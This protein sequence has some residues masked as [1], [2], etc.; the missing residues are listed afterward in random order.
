MGHGQR[1]RQRAGDKTQEAAISLCFYA[2]FIRKPL[3]T[4]R[5]ALYGSARAA[6]RPAR[7]FGRSQLNG[8]V[9]PVILLPQSTSLLIDAEEPDSE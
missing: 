3:H 2:H 6:W 9:S 4:F 5:N 8:L 1:L 7:I